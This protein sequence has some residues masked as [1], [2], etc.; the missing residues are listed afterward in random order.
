MLVV[1]M[2]IPRSI[3]Q[4][5][6]AQIARGTWNPPEQTPANYDVSSESAKLLMAYQTQMIVRLAMFEGRRFLWSRGLS[7]GRALVE[8]WV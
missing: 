6:L 5:Q 2:I 7:I 8:R 1:A 3:A 4:S